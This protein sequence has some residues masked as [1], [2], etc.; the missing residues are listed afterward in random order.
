MKKKK[1]N[2]NNNDRRAQVIPSIEEIE[3]ALQSA[4]GLDFTA[5]DFFDY[6]DAIGWSFGT[7]PIRNW[8]A[9]LRTWIRNKDYFA[10]RRVPR[11]KQTLRMQPRQNM[12]DRVAQA[13]EAAQQEWERRYEESRQNHVSYEEYKRMKAA[14][15]VS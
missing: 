5:E 13:R 3:S 4:T 10:G 12:E 9:L 8:R 7:K 6:Y 15:M 11:Q 14:G 2:N 1:D